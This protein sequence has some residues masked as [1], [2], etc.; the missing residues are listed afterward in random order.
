M[1]I[2]LIIQESNNSS[3]NMFIDCIPISI[4]TGTTKLMNKPYLKTK[5]KIKSLHQICGIW[6][7]NMK[8]HQS[9]L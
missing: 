7:T 2:E 4:Q 1:R 8:I 5:N 9:N 3:N 6:I